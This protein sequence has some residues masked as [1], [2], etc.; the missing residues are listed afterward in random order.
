MRNLLIGASAEQ[1]L[2]Q[3]SE[4]A[5]ALMLKEYHRCRHRSH[6][7]VRVKTICIYLSKWGSKT[8]LKVLGVIMQALMQLKRQLT[9]L[10]H[11]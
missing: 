1:Q 10:I 4:L 6:D 11:N 7:L 3:S 8:L 2:Y 9:N 5:E